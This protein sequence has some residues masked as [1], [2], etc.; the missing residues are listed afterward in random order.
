[1]ALPWEIISENVLN[2]AKILDDLL[3]TSNSKDVDWIVKNEDGTVDSKIVPNLAKLAGLFGKRYVGA[4]DTPPTKRL[5][6]T[7][8]E[9]GDMYFDT[10]KKQMMVYNGTEWK[11]VAYAA[12][13]IK[14]SFT[15][16]GSTTEFTVEGGYEP[17]MGMVFLNGVNVTN[18]VDLTSGTVIKFKEAPA[19]GDII[20]AYFYNSFKV[21]DAYTKVEIDNILKNYKKEALIPD[22]I[23]DDFEAE[24]YNKYYVDTSKKEINVTLPSNPVRGEQIMIFD[25]YGNFETNNCILNGNGNTIMGESVFYLN[26]NNKLYTIEFNG[27]EW[28]VR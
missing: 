22:D 12:A 10:V 18:E 9:E 5:D 25:P 16:D 20:E 6:G 1:M 26:M 14:A 28:R 3:D 8:I 27:K 19:D 4:S 13:L 11:P 7:A 17:N 24:P 2:V 15:G 21:A 23:V